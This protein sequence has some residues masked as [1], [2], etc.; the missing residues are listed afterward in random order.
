MQRE[1]VSC[2]ACCLGGDFLRRAA[3]GVRHG[4][5]NMRQEG[6]LVAPCPGLR[7]QVARREVRRVRLEQQPVFRDLLHQLEQVLSA[8]LVADPAGDADVQAEVEVGLQLFRCAGEAVRD[9]L[10]DFVMFQ[11]LAEPRVGIPLMQEKRLA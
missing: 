7:P 5:E 4:V 2:V 3:E 6:G 11:D 8:A 1:K 9:R 10:L